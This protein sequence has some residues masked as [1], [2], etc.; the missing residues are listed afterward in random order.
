M[1]KNVETGMG[2]LSAKGSVHSPKLIVMRYMGDEGKEV[3]GLVG[4]G[5]TYD[6]GGF[7]LKLLQV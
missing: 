1:K 5:L 2:L 3:L 4:K 6:S 7:S